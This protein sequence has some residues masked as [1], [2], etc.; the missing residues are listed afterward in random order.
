MPK[1]EITFPDGGK[2]ILDME[3]PQLIE[4]ES[5][6]WA[7]ERQKGIF[8]KRKVWEAVVTNVRVF[9]YNHEEGRMEAYCLLANAEFLVLKSRRVR[10]SSWAGPFVYY[11]GIGA[12]A[13]GSS[14]E[15]I[16]V[17]TVAVMSGGR[18]VTEWEVESPRD[19]VRFINAAKKQIKFCLGKGLDQSNTA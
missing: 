9:Q 5:I 7:M 6:I 10:R 4:G 16:T 1:L 13:G 12:Y 2:E 14:S 11:R 17:G 18:I 8:N 15:Y 19:F 3:S